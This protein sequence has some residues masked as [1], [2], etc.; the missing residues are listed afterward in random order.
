MITQKF[1]QLF[2]QYLVWNDHSEINQ[3]DMFIWCSINIIILDA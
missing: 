2:L 1:Q 3:Y